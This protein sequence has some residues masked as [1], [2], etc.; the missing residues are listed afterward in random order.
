MTRNTERRVEVAA[1]IL[2]RGLADRTAAMFNV[3]LRDNVK[4]REQDSDG[5]YRRV[6][7]SV[8]QP[9]NSQQF[10]YEQAYK[11]AEPAPVPAP[12]P[13]T[14]PVTVPPEPAD[15]VMR[16]KVKKVRN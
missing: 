14:V 5:N 12:I 3:M 15:G 9:L 11:Y 6:E 8:G 1:P 4:A 16:V 2:D 13:A 7:N 10:F